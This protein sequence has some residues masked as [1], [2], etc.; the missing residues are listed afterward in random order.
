MK[1]IMSV[2]LGDASRDFSVETDIAGERVLLERRGTGGDIRLAR[3]LMRLYDGRVTSFGIGG[4]NLHYVVGAAEYRMRAA[5]ALRD[6]ATRTPVADGSLI[7]RF[8]EPTIID[9]LARNGVQF[10]GKRAVISSALDRW[11]LAEALERAGSKIGILDAALALRL[12][13]VFQ[14]TRVFGFAARATMP[15]L[16]RLPLRWLYPRRIVVAAGGPAAWRGGP[17]VGLAERAMASAD[18]IAGDSYLAWRCM[19]RRLDGKTLIVSTATQEEVDEM[20]ARGAG[21]V[22]STSPSVAGRSF[23][24]NMIEALIVA[25]DGRPPAKIPAA[26][27]RQWWERLGLRFRMETGLVPLSH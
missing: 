9:H 2:S 3:D 4:A 27:Y 6:A 24:A 8:I 14:G 19:P 26:C 1:W 15:A 20:M 18:V 10:R 16:R 5:W 21:V 25:F 23:G 13:V 11:Y 17:A 7:K 12:P 22:A